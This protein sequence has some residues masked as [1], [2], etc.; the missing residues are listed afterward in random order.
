MERMTPSPDILTTYHGRRESINVKIQLQRSRE[1]KIEHDGLQAALQFWPPKYVI[2]SLFALDIRADCRSIPAIIS[3]TQQGG[4]DDVA[5]VPNLDTVPGFNHLGQTP[6]SNSNS[7]YPGS[8]G[9]SAQNGFASLRQEP[10]ALP[11]GNANGSEDQSFWDLI[12][13]GTV[14]DLDFSAFLQNFNGDGSAI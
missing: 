2:I 14:E 5:A 11:G 9:L 13:G 10:I 3:T 7:S 1:M 12:N 4:L 8:A 6:V